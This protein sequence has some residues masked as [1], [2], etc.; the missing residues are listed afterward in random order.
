MSERI[1]KNYKPDELEAVL[2]LLQNNSFCNFDLHEACSIVKILHA[3]GY[4]IVKI[5]K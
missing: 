4:R 2:A 3:R 1:N 5:S